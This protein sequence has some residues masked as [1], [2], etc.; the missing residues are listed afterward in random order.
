MDEKHRNED[1]NW[2]PSGMGNVNVWG[3][4]RGCRERQTDQGVRTRTW[5]WLG[6]GKTVSGNRAEN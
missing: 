5:E 4:S 1:W 6:K 3:V 2:E